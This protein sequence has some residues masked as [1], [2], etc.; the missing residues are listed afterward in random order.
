[1]I[2]ERIENYNRN[3]Y[4]LDLNDTLTDNFGSPKLSE[5]AQETFEGPLK[6]KECK[7]ILETFQKD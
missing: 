7:K 4:T 2:L 6:Y 3:P 1:M 5:E